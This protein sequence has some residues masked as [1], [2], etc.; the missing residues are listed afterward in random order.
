MW[1]DL[2]VFENPPLSASLLLLLYFTGICTVMAEPAA[3]N[4]NYSGKH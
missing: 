3:T 2:P 4:V 1:E